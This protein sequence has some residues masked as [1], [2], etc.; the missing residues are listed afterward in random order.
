[1]KGFLFIGIL[2]LIFFHPVIGLL[3]LL[4]LVLSIKG[5]ELNSGASSN[6]NV[7]YQH[8]VLVRETIYA[9]PSYHYRPRRAEEIC[10]TP[11]AQPQSQS[12][13]QIPARVQQE[14]E[15][16]AKPYRSKIY[17]WEMQDKLARVNFG[18]LN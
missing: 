12:Q 13:P 17:P 9:S 2:I 8:E 11:E 14:P 18:Q 3:A 4:F 10:S 1:M 7:V 15:I 6:R 16:L 5:E